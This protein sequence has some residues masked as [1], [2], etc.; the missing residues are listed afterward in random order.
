MLS[1]TCDQPLAYMIY[2]CSSA[3]L[4]QYD[5]YKFLQAFFKDPGDAA[6]AMGLYLQDLKRAGAKKETHSL[7]SCPYTLN[8]CSQHQ[9]RGIETRV[10]ETHSDLSSRFA[11][12]PTDADFFQKFEP[13]AVQYGRDFKSF[14]AAVKQSKEEEAQEAL[15]EL[16]ATLLAIEFED[17]GVRKS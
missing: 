8:I 10:R 1:L 17:D 3:R 7:P 9:R 4:I 15:M 13:V 14:E 12:M 11:G 16:R 5:V 6:V 2:H